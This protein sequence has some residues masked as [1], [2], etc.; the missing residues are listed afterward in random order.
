MCK[1]DLA[2]CILTNNEDENLARCLDSV[3]EVGA[4]LIV[5]DSGQSQST[6]G[7]CKKL[8]A[9]YHPYD[10]NNNFALARNY[11][12]EQALSKNVYFLDSDEW[13]AKED[14]VVNISQLLKYFN[15]TDLAQA[16]GVA[17]IIDHQEEDGQVML[18]PQ[19]KQR[20]FNKE[21]FN[22]DKEVLVDET[23]T[24]TLG[25][26]SLAFDLVNVTKVHHD[27]K[28]TA[29]DRQAK[30]EQRLLL[31]LKELEAHPGEGRFLLSL[32]DCYRE[33]NQYQA[34]KL[35]YD[36]IVSAT[37]GRNGAELYQTVV[38]SEGVLDT[39]DYHF[40]A[41]EIYGMYH[42]EEKALSHFQRILALQEQE[43]DSNYV[44]A[45]HYFIGKHYENQGEFKDAKKHYRLSSDYPDSVDALEAIL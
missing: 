19:L 5:I 22:Y 29:A 11:A 16:R 4:E 13:W 2:I 45:A 18:K 36:Q 38:D 6:E 25:F 33:G 30:A 7:L 24:S 20:A 1:I 21:Y 34:A 27:G 9:Q 43:V 12:L 14:L 42:E 10:W 8:G 44:A 26:D 23:L 28:L 41:G 32:A 40:M 3:K 35:V 37:T 17:T 15:R 39:A 31:V